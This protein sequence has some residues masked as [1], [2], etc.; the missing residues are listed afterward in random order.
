M[1]VYEVTEIRNGAC[2]IVKD[3]G[4]M[5][6]VYIKKGVIR[7]WCEHASAMPVYDTDGQCP[8]QSL[9]GNILIG[10]TKTGHTWFQWERSKCCSLAHLFDWCLFFCTKK[11]QGP[12]GSST[13]TEHMPLIIN[14]KLF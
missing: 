7:F 2:V 6:K 12:N 10:T 1:S 4:R 3:G 9:C 8:D 13:R 14:K 5:Y 11:N